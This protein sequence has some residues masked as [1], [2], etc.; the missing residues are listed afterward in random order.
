M[1]KIKMALLFF[2]LF[3]ATQLFAEDLSMQQYREL[4][5]DYRNGQHSST[6]S[7]LINFGVKS[8]IE[9]NNDLSQV[10]DPLR[11]KEKKTIIAAIALQAE[12]AVQSTESNRAIYINEAIALAKLLDVKQATAIEEELHLAVSL[13]LYRRLQIVDALRFIEPVAE[14]FDSTVAIQYAFANLAELNGSLIFLAKA[15]QAY[16]HILSLQPE[17][18][19]AQIRLGRVLSVLGHSSEAI[20]ILKT[21]V[22]KL[23]NFA[24]RTIGLLSLG[25]AYRA[26]GDLLQARHYYREAFTIDPTSQP[27]AVSLS[28]TLRELGEDQQSRKVIQTSMKTVVTNRMDSWT[29]YQLGDSVNA[30]VI[31]QNF[32]AKFK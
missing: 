22:F 20:A 28:H 30:A 27:A 2:L 17:N 4:L 32:R 1:Q 5:R 23:N 25:N 6:A 12:T 18:T 8:L 7:K 10:L 31:W 21:A 9:R 3:S 11:L 16:E 26:S 24:H 15:R 13:S 29:V 14:R 19:L